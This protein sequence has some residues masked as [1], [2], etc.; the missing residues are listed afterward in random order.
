MGQF[1]PPPHHSLL[2]AATGARVPSLETPW[3]NSYGTE[4]DATEYQAIPQ[5]C[6][7]SPGLTC[8]VLH[9]QTLPLPMLVDGEGGWGK[10]TG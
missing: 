5:S 8:W 4:I 1:S 6:N 2:P 9:N 3:V 10:G 7:H